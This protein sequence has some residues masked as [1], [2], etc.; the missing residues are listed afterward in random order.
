[1][2]KKIMFS[3]ILTVL[4]PLALR[5]QEITIIPN[6]LLEVGDKGSVTGDYVRIRSGPT[7][8]HRIITKVNRGTPLTVVERGVLEK[9]SDM[10]NYWYHVKLDSLEIEGWMYGAFIK[11]NEKTV[12]VTL[13]DTSQKLDLKPIKTEA[14]PSQKRITLKETGVIA[15]SGTS[16]TSDDL[17]QNGIPEIILLSPETSGRYRD[18]VGYEQSSGGFTK[19]YVIQ[20]RNAGI[21]SIKTFHHSSLGSPLIIA[22]GDNYSYFYTYDVK[23]EQTRLIY[24]LDTPDVTVGLLDGQNPYLVYLNKNKMNS[25]DGTITYFVQAEKI[26]TAKNRFSLKDR[27]EYK[28]PLP[29]KKLIA[30]DMDGDNN[31]EIVTEIGGKES[32]GG[33]VI[34]SLEDEKITRLVNSGINTYN[35]NQF[36]SMWGISLEGRPKL[37]IYS[38]NP[39]NYSDADSDFGFLT[40]SY[41]DSKLIVEHFYPVNKM[42]DDVNNYREILHYSPN[43]NSF[44]F[45]VMDFDVDTSEYIVRKADLN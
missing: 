23:K 22:Q 10:E 30:F 21:R 28:K 33:I 7:L 38:N 11:K 29:V 6:G 26:V 40:A 44:P 31:A 8:E 19:S 36:L 20:I 18:I 17:N 15:D 14:P 1:M 39:S 27:V 9:I 43:G 41:S 5:A 45:V 2:G 42:L 35:N 24:K 12:T 16:I 25:Q 13:S 37:V 3:L 32:G 4:I 34:L